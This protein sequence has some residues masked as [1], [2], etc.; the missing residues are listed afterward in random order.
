MPPVPGGRAAEQLRGVMMSIR[1]VAL[2][3]PKASGVHIFTKFPLPRL[4]LPILG[5]IL[6][7][8]GIAV[9]IYYQEASELDWDDIVSSDLV[10]ISSIITTAPIAYD[11]LRQVKRR[12]DVPVVFGGPHNTFLP[13][14]ALEQGADYVVRGE[15]EE[16][17]PELISCLDAGDNALLASVLGL[18]YLRDGEMH[19][20]PDR[21][22]AKS[23]SSF[24]WPDFSLIRDYRK[25]F[26]TP[27]LTSRGCPFDCNFCQVTK[28]FGRSYRFRSTEDIIGEMRHLYGRDPRS[29]FFFYDD[30]FAASVKRTKELLQRMIQE[31]MT[32]RW[33][34]MVRADVVK[35]AELM[36][37]M[38]ASGCVYVYLGLESINPETLI[39]YRKSQTIE[40]V[41]RAVD[42][43]HDH[44]IR[45]HG[46][47]IA[48]SDEDEP[49]TMMETVRFARQT[50][51]D[52]MHFTILTPMP[53]TEIFAQMKAEDRIFD[54]N[55][56]HY[57]GMHTVFYPHHMS[58][59]YLQYTAIIGSMRKFYSVPHCLGMGLRLKFR[60]MLFRIYAHL[61]VRQWWKRNR[62]WLAELSERGQGEHLEQDPE[63][64]ALSV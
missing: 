10:G 23:L 63:A 37:L 51:I 6:R 55:W 60:V 32:P 48:G 53:G 19:H 52:T 8:A 27:M 4:G 61:T 14:E 24:P 17:L 15:G 28:M 18:S 7:R 54:L 11:I 49:G 3:E 57:D 42:V 9:T 36:R 64:P 2:I 25:T 12:I 40:D 59:A 46:M 22:L 16:T 29:T 33:T 41:T 21:P 30:N 34:A 5:A 62:Q 45:V 56:E 44:H 43:F 47:F 35:D 31:H 1:K 39:K 50:G 20:N 13:E 58:P 38:R 26:V